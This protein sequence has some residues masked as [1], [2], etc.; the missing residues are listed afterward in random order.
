MQQLVLLPP[1]SLEYPKS[2][3]H[4]SWTIYAAGKIPPCLSCCPSPLAQGNGQKL[5]VKRYRLF[6][7]DSAIEMYTS[8]IRMI[9]LKKPI[10]LEA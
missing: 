10:Y 4:G 3:Q 7:G 2:L 1:A 8:I 5:L 9:F 6:H